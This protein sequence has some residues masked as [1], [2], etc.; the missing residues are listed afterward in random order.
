MFELGPPNVSLG[1]VRGLMDKLGFMV[2]IKGGETMRRARKDS[3]FKRNFWIR[4]FERSSWI[5]KSKR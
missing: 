1:G 4:S 5:G 3:E 2:R